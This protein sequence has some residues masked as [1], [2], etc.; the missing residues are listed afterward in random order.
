MDL[1]GL[2]QSKEILKLVVPIEA[3]GSDEISTLLE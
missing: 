2:L 1:S 3:A